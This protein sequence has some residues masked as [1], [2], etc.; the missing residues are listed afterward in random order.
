MTVS[1]ACDST[2]VYAAQSA[3]LMTHCRRTI[4]LLLLGSY[5]FPGALAISLEGLP[6]RRITI[7]LI[8]MQSSYPPL[9]TGLATLLWI[10]LFSCVTALP[11]PPCDANLDGAK[12]IRARPNAAVAN[13]RISQRYQQQPKP[14]PKKRKTLSFPTHHHDH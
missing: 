2:V 10:S 12:C 1:V 7:A 9:I 13:A 14:P 8:A 6:T 3:K 4:I 11:G 5:I